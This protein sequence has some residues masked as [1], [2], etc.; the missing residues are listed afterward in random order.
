VPLLSQQGSTVDIR[1]TLL[2]CLALAGASVAA[3]WP[4]TNAQFV[5]LDDPAYV[6][7][8]FRVQSGLTSDNAKWAF[9]T[10]D[11][12]LWQPLTWLS[13]M[14]DCE[15][16]GLN[17]PAMHSV[18]LG[19][20]VATAVLLFL[21][22][23][24]LTRAWWPSVIV[25][26]LFALHPLRVESV[27]W[28][29]ERKDVLST[30]FGIL[31]LAS[32][33]E[34]ALRRCAGCYAAALLFFAL[35]LMSKAMLVTLPFA[36]L[37]LDLWPLR[38][39]A[40]Q[41]PDW[42]VHLRR[43]LLEK[44]P[45][46]ALAA[47]SIALTLLAPV[48]R[49]GFARLPFGER[50]ANAIVS[51]ARYLGKTFWPSDLAVFY[52]YTGEW[53]ALAFA[54]AIALLL[55]LTTLAVVTVRRFPWV[56]VGW[57]WFVGTLVPVIGI[58]QVGD[59]S[60]ADRFTYVPSIGLLLALVWTA[61]ELIQRHRPLRLAGIAATA[62]IIVACAFVTHRQAGYW[63]NSETLFSHALKV[64]PP[65]VLILNSLGS[66]LLEQGRIPEAMERFKAVLTLNPQDS[67]AWGNIGNI[68]AR[69]RKFDAALEHYR[70][71]LRC[72]PKRADIP[73]VL[74][75][76]A[77]ILATHWDASLRNGAEAVRLAEQAVELTG[78][79]HPSLLGTLAA[80]YAEAGRFEEAVTSAE[81][82]IRLA[83]KHEQ[84][85][86]AI[87]NREL[88]AYYRQRRPWHEPLP[89]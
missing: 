57:F 35:G 74:N 48:H 63:K 52:P 38:R 47:A 59:Q 56:F 34:Y 51:Y 32:Y 27:A 45:F 10:F 16:F 4:V 25:A 85:Q 39:I 87:K 72:K 58:V 61:R 8:N 53:P 66:G 24:R 86:L 31:T 88:L 30:F 55:I 82:A 40:I 80:A 71:A 33:G 13:L 41:A 3:F 17:A 83:D 44:L 78:R 18:N 12:S 73:L 23:N 50:L 81:E 89:P 79:Q 36:L 64:T 37:L 19:F 46:F 9:T 65:S 26:A 68:Y 5:N 49:A 70:T 7:D 20:H 11:G 14:L 2:V 77:W 21:L 69:E 43:L 62:A 60:M 15:L 42:P 67:Q 22:F 75:N 54:G 28:I 84:T 6:L 29:T 76:L 1:N